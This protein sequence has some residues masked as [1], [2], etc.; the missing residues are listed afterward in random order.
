MWVMFDGTPAGH[1]SVNG[2]VIQDSNLALLLRVT[3]E[4]LRTLTAELEAAG[5]FSRTESGVIYCRRMVRDAKRRETNALN[6]SKGGNP[7]LQHK[8]NPVAKSVNQKSNPNSANAVAYEVKNSGKER[9]REPIHEATLWP[10]F[11]DFWT[12]YERKGNRKTA[13]AEWKKLSQADREACV[14][15]ISAYIQSKPD[16]MYRKDGE[17]FLKHRVWED[18]ITI[19]TQSAN[20]RHSSQDDKRAAVARLFAEDIASENS[21]GGHGDE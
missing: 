3:P 16:K 18:E 4:E 2:S 17:R 15:S 7:N 11:D 19:P 9:A 6:G 20:G 14:N 10:S 5:V 8:S 12:A 21:S 1:L 13:D